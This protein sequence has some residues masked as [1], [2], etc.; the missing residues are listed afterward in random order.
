MQINNLKLLSKFHVGRSKRSRVISK[1][2]HSC[3]SHSLFGKWPSKKK[4]TRDA[5][6]GL[7]EII[8]KKDDS[9]VPFKGHSNQV[10]LVNQNVGK[11]LKF[12]LTTS[13]LYTS[14]RF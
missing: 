4:E 14:C 12:I 10:F 13:E 7:F 3:A 8:L 6:V 5:S 2:V 1:S 9:G 11:S